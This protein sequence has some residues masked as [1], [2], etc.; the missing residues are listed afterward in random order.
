[1]YNEKKIKLIQKLVLLILFVLGIAVGVG[2]SQLTS[3]SDE[4]TASKA[5]QVAK[6]TIED[7]THKKSL[8]NKDVNNFLIAYFTKKDLSENRMRYKPFMTQSMYNQEKETEELPI[9]Q[10][11]KGYVVNQ[12][13]DKATIYIDNDNLVAL[14]EAEYHNT[15]LTEKGSTDGALVDTPEKQTLKITYIEENGHYKVN[16]I[17]K[18]FL[19]TTGETAGNNAYDVEDDLEDTTESSGSDDHQTES[20][21]VESNKE[22]NTSESTQNT[23]QNQPSEVQESTTK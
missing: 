21:T 4:E 11:Y 10:A 18:I 22:S 9:N 6:K 12:V 1:M 3:S 8:T 16:R 17:N 14:V 15:Q 2:I 23:E 20:T 5:E 19:T 13:F 7:K